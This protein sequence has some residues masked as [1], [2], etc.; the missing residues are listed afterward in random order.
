METVTLR[1]ELFRLLRRA[2]PNGVLMSDIERTLRHRRGWLGDWWLR[3]RIEYEI[4]E[5]YLDGYVRTV[6]DRHT[7]RTRYMAH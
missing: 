6:W 2:C 7:R 3:Y 1:S 4:K 5:L